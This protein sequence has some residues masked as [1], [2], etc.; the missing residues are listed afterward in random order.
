MNL[1]AL[2]V[3]YGIEPAATASLRSLARCRRHERCTLR[4]IVWDNSP[5][6]SKVDWLVLGLHGDYVATPENLGLSTIYNRVTAGHLQRGEHLLLLDQDTDLPDDFL[7][8]AAAA[9]EAHPNVDLFLPM[10]RANGR[11]ASP[12]TYWCGWGKQ[13][14]VRLVGSIPSKRVCAINSGMIISA[15]YMLGSFPGYDERLRFYGTDTQFMLDYIDRRRRLC[16]IDSVIAHDLSFF[17][18]AAP[19]RAQKFNVMKAAYGYIYENRPWIQQVAVRL[20]MLSISI[21][22]AL[23]HRDPDFLRREE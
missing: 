9:I 8:K 10:V 15:A 7:L 6:P 22:Y 20:V 11:W 18:A 21:R 12:V 14:R 1:L 5:Q 17:S 13:W 4:T 3:V 23:K 19:T 2:I 16:M